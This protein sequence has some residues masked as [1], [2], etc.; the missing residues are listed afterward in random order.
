MIT[1][2][3]LDVLTAASYTYINMTKKY[4]VTIVENPN[5]SV[6]IEKVCTSSTK[7]QN[8][9]SLKPVDKRKFTRDFLNKVERFETK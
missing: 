3:S 7:R 5:G 4:Q 1:K 2:K 8:R 9:V 6:E